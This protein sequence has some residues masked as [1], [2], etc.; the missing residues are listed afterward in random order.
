VTTISATG[1]S[2]T[3]AGEIGIGGKQNP[4][5]SALLHTEAV[6]G[7]GYEGH[8]GLIQLTGKGGVGLQTSRLLSGQVLAMDKSRG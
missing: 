2:F 8:D 5:G 4:I 6:L 1:G 3:A 7:V